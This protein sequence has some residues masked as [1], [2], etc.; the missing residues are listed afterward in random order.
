LTDRIVEWS[1]AHPEP[2]RRAPNPRLH[3]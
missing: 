1:R 2:V 3:R